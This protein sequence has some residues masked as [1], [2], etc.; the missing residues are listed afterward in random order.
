MGNGQCAAA[1][2]IA[3]FDIIAFMAHV[4][5]HPYGGGGAEGLM[6]NGYAT[7]AYVAAHTS[8]AKLLALARKFASR[9]HRQ[10][11]QSWH[12]WHSFRRGTTPA[13]SL[14]PFGISHRRLAPGWAQVT[15]ISPTMPGCGLHR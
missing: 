4:W 10:S 3:A 9:P 5:Q 13:T 12:T 14:M 1:G 11:W 2:E 15:T 7:L 6:L 8:R